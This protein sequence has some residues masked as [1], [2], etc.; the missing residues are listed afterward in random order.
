MLYRLLQLLLFTSILILP[1]R[2]SVLFDFDYAQFG[3]DSTSN[4]VELYYSF[5]QNALSVKKNDTITI[6]EAVLHVVITDT[7]NN[8]VLIERE[9]QLQNEVFDLMENKSLVGVL[10]FLLPGGSLKL[11]VTGTDGINPE[12][13]NSI[14]EYLRIDP[15]L[16]SDSLS[17]S[18]IQLASRI[19]QE[20]SNTSSIFYK[21]SLEVIPQ[22]TSVFGENQPVL[23]YYAEVYNIPTLDNS[24][25][26]LKLT[27]YVFN[28]RG[29]TVNLKIKELSKNSSSRVE[30]GTVALNKLPSDTYTLAISIVDSADNFGLFSVKKFF[31]YNP[32]VP[33]VDTVIGKSASLLGSQFNAMSEEELDELFEKSKYIAS[34]RDIEQYKKINSL[35][36]KQEFLFNFWKSREG[37]PSAKASYLMEYLRRI[38]ISNERFGSFTKKG[39]KT[40][41]GR[42]F[43]VYGEPSEIERYP[44][45]IDTKPYEIWH[46]NEI[47]G[48]VIFVFADMQGF[49]DHTLIHSTLRG[50]LRDDYWQ[51]RITSF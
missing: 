11:E 2:K 5:N 32:S 27:Q 29:D 35:E 28:S 4:Y 18:D 50:E 46:Y 16:D 49:S 51:R 22:P 40:D 39:W 24:N 34:S 8:D 10:G 48:G 37:N 33:I 30:I 20:S 25:S 6:V 31:V 1:Q 9:W 19:I 36:G 3:H 13:F 43:I 42:V 15:L 38:E 26:K 45:Q 14:T 47:E 44:N 12:N 7:S 41:R 23:F 21:N 17:L